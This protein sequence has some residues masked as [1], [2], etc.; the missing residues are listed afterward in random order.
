MHVFSVYSVFLPLSS[1]SVSA[2]AITDTHI[3]KAIGRTGKKTKLG[4]RGRGFVVYSV[5][6]FDRYGLKLIGIN[7]YICNFRQP[8][9]SK[10]TGHRVK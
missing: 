7:R 3:S 9:P 4:P 6:A 8:Y 2:F 1:M 10:S 5:C